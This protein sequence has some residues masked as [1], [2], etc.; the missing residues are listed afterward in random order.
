M[1]AVQLTAEVLPDDHGNTKA[2]ATALTGP[3]NSIIAQIEF[4]TDADF[5]SIPFYPAR[6]Y[7]IEIKTNTV[8]DVEL[9]ITPPSWPVAYID[10]NTIWQS[11]VEIIWTNNGAFGNWH[12]SVVGMFEYTT[13]SY[14]LAVWEAP[15]NQDVDG[16]GMTDSWENDHL[17]SVTNQ[18]GDDYNHD[19]QSNWQDFLAHAMGGS[20][21]V[22]SI[23]K[24]AENDLVG[25]YQAA[26]STYKVYS[27]TN[28]FGPWGYVEDHLSGDT[29]GFVS[30]TNNV[31][32]N[33]VRFYRVDFVY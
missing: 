4:D 27:A 16:D 28:V 33:P 14:Q 9:S 3:S 6:S 7:I 13:G 32:T 21:Q 19:G 25:W 20:V 12:L 24:A 8:W 11:P 10:T 15:N 17:G 26:F 23:D 18:P 22:E 2:D 31:G 1:W 29:S 30:W 5:F